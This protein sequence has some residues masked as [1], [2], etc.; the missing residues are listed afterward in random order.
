LIISFK[1]FVA[2]FN[3]ACKIPN[4]LRSYRL[5]GDEDRFLNPKDARG[6]IVVQ[7][8]S[9]EVAEVGP[10]DPD[11]KV[12]WQREKTDNAQ[13]PFPFRCALALRCTIHVP[14]NIG[15]GFGT[16]VGVEE[17]TIGFK[18]QAAWNGYA[19]IATAAAALFQ[20]AAML[21]PT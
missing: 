19:A 12:W 2:D 17:L 3:S 16:L 8:D 14:T 4:R 20:A 18:K 10:V 7:P 5:A 1:C 21:S 15:S 11:P 6:Y 13:F 9:F